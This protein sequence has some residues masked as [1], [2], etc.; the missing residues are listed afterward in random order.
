MRGASVFKP[1]GS[2]LTPSSRLSLLLG[3]C[4]RIA[5][6]PPG[7]PLLS[8]LPRLL[9]LGRSPAKNPVPARFAQ[10]VALA[11]DGH[12]VA[13]VQIPVENRR[14]DG[15]VAEDHPPFAGRPV[16]RQQDAAGLVAR[17]HKVE[18]EVCRAGTDGQIAELVYYGMFLVMYR[19]NAN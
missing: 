6:I 15:Q 13:V 19:I 8:G 2:S 5:G 7:K 9:Q 16:C 10:A 3:A 11:A 14:G 18:E 4:F 1:A 12:D 17:G